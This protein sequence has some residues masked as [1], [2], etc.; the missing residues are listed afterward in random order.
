MSRAQ[1]KTTLTLLSEAVVDL[2]D[3][4]WGTSE[5]K[6][7]ASIVESFAEVPPSLEVPRVHMH[8]EIA[9]RLIAQQPNLSG[10]VLSQLIAAYASGSCADKNAVAALFTSITGR[11]D[12]QGAYTMSEIAESLSAAGATWSH[13]IRSMAL[14]ALEAQNVSNEVLY[15]FLA[16]SAMAHWMSATVYIKCECDPCSCEVY[17]TRVLRSLD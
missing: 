4:A 5:W 12:Q 11:Y 3:T 1:A 17:L 14:W 8:A 16:L 9:R 7:M 13:E 15:L 2:S 10:K 6:S